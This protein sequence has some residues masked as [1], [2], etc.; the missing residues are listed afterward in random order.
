MV[1]FLFFDAD[2]V[3][4]A[5]VPCEQI[6]AVLGIEEFSKGLDSTH[7]RNDACLLAAKVKHSIDKIVTCTIIAQLH[8]KALVKKVLKVTRL[9]QDFML[10]QARPKPLP[11]CLKH[12]P[13]EKLDL[14]VSQGNAD[15]PQRRAP[16]RVGIFAPGRLLVDRPEADQ[17]VD[18]VRKRDG[19]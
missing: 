8:L 13:G 5:L 15:H 18:F 11:V 17:R 2:D 7:D 1:V 6:L 4:R 12:R 3:S 9:L 19:H 16:Q 14:A 10:R